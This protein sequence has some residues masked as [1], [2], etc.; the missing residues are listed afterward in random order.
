MI[1]NPLRKI[2]ML[3]AV[4]NKDKNLLNTEEEETK[5]PHPGR[6]YNEDDNTISLLKNPNK[7]SI[8]FIKRH[9][10]VSLDEMNEV[11]KKREDISWGLLTLYII[12][13]GIFI[14]VLIKAELDLENKLFIIMVLIVSTSSF[15]PSIIRL[16]NI[17]S[18]QTLKLISSIA[19]VVTIIII[20]LLLQ[21]FG[22]YT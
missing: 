11:Q 21:N 15:I 18:K 22:D 17:I 2:V 13:I 9:E 10:N 14:C 6:Y 16:H 8:G 4:E 3:R 7:V 12:I 20:H 5:E 1:S 19:P